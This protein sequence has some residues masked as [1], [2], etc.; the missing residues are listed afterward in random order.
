MLL[1][2]FIRK[3]RDIIRIYQIF[4]RHILNKF[5]KLQDELIRRNQAIEF[6]KEEIQSFDKIINELKIGEKTLMQSLEAYKIKYQDL[7]DETKKEINKQ[8]QQFEITVQQLEKEFLDEKAFL[9]DQINQMQ[10]EITMLNQQIQE[11]SRITS[12]YR[13][14]F[15]I[16]N[17]KIIQQLKIEYEQ[18]KNKQCQEITKLTSQLEIISQQLHENQ[19]LNQELQI[20]LDILNKHNENTSQQLIRLQNGF[21][22]LQNQQENDIFEQ[23]QEIEHL[24]DQ[25]SQLT[26]LFEQN[27]LLIQ[28]LQNELETQKQKLIEIQKQYQ[29]QGQVKQEISKSQFEQMKRQIESQI[30]LLDYEKKTILYQFEMKKENAKNGSNKIIKIFDADFFN[31]YLLVIRRYYFLFY[32]SYKLNIN[33]LKLLKIY[34]HQENIF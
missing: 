33:I 1:Y 3:I 34:I 18:Q 26:E 5:Q 12:N 6:Q 31:H 29:I 7:I 14:G 23:N 24:N 9:I 17:K 25:I 2:N 28:R 13:I 22:S 11:S 32:K 10:Y 21:E 30:E 8:N 20:A 27:N 15:R 4:N 16:K 19:E